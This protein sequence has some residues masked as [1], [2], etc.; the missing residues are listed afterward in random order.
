MPCGFR[1]TMR[2]SCACISN[3]S[4]AGVAIA[5]ESAHLV[6]ASI[7]FEESPMPLDHDDESKAHFYSEGDRAVPPAMSRSPNVADK[8][9]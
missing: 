4:M 7:S 2:V 6:G 3:V 1:M 8:N 9:R 5:A